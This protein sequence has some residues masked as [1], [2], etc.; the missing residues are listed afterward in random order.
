[1]VPREASGCAHVA[2]SRHTR[3]QEKNKL[4]PEVMLVQTS[5]Y[6]CIASIS[7]VE[8]KNSSSCENSD[9]KILFIGIA[10]SRF[11]LESTYF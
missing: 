6:N 3:S 9:K 5:Y 4:Q 10:D 11:K 8:V 1:M 2:S 7:N